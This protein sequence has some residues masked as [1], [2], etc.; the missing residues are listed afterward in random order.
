M[1]KQLLSLALA[2]SFALAFVPVI[3][4][5]VAADYGSP[6][7]FLLHIAPPAEGS[8]PISNREELAAIANNLSGKYH[9]TADI[10]LSDGAWTPIGSVYGEFT[11]VFDGQGFVIR[12]LT[13]TSAR[14]SAINYLGLFGTA[15]GNAHVP[16]YP[17]KLSGVIKNVGLEQTNIQIGD[18]SAAIFAGGISGYGGIISNCYNTGTIT[19]SNRTEAYAVSAG[20]ISGANSSIDSSYNMAS[21]SASSTC[22]PSWNK[23]DSANAGGICGFNGNVKN[24]YNTGL[25]TAIDA[26]DSIITLS[27]RPAR[28]GGIVG[29]N[30]SGFSIENCCNTGDIVSYAQRAG[31]TTYSGTIVGY[32]ADGSTVRN[33]YWNIDSKQSVD[34]NE[35]STDDKQG[36]GYGMGQATGLTAEQMQTQASFPGW[37]FTS[38]WAFKPGVNSR[39]PVLR[40][41]HEFPSSWAEYSVNRAI[42]AGIV[43]Q[44]L[45]TKYTADITRAEFCALAVAV[46]ERHTGQTITARAAFS[47]TTDVNV[48]KAAGAGIVGGGGDGKFNP[49]GTFNRERAAVLLV[50]LLKAMNIE[51]GNNNADFTDKGDISGWALEQVGQAQAAGLVSGSGGKYDPKGKFTREAGILLM[52]NLWDYL[53]S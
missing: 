1:K 12:N 25:I 44:S 48:E 23:N 17:P 6:G 20:G 3:P 43:P 40:A 30:S 28:A 42:T 32:S 35:L 18:I 13:I 33:S 34:G 4:V 51:L 2:V 47:D 26:R 21:V 9:L 8:I 22:N 31:I 50:N 49:G 52:L 29:S 53:N 27:Y 14:A 39:Y 16:I 45:Q 19:V 5:A 24:C 38:V 46:Y 15:G 7:R 37:D 11:G 10:D 36:L 41:F